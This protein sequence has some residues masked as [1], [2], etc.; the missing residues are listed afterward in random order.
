MNEL[1]ER[2][3]AMGR[4]G[5]LLALGVAFLAAAAGAGLFWLTLDP[6]LGV[7]EAQRIAEGGSGMS[8]RWRTRGL[9]F[10]ALLTFAMALPSAFLG[11]RLLTQ[12]HYP[13]ADEVFPPMD[14]GAIAD[15]LSQRTEDLCVC[16][17]C[18]VM[19]PA[20]FSTGACPVCAS[21][22]EYHEVQSDEDAQMVLAAMS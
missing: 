3:E 5:G 14:V 19:V 12:R 16:T 1:L 15:A 4:P 17:R 7:E 21:A 9:R 11:V 10:S 6:A 13:R 20:A 8:T 2:L 22:V 18:R